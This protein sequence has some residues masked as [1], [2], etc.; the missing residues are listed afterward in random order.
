MT[1]VV[2]ERLGRE[3]WRRDILEEV[4]RR[5]VVVRLYSGSIS[6]LRRFFTGSTSAL[7]RLA[8]TA[9]QAFVRGAFR[10]QVQS[11]GPVR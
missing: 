1:G 8:V 2:R 11:G 5:S 7:F 10:W 4:A 3:D 9:S 6:V